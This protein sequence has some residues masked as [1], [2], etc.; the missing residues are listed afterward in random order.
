MSWREALRQL[1]LGQL[2]LVQLGRRRQG[3]LQQEFQPEQ[4]PL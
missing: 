2:G 1:G 4:R 3:R